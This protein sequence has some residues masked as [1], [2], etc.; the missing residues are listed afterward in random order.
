M[1]SELRSQ[2]EQWVDRGESVGPDALLERVGLQLSTSELSAEVGETP[3]ATRL[4]PIS[5]F[6]QWISKPALVALAAALMTFLAVGAIGVLTFRLGTG[7]DAVDQPPATLTTPTPTTIPPVPETTAPPSTVASDATGAENGDAFAVDWM[8]QVQDVAVSKH[9]PVYVSSSSAIASRDQAGNW[10]LI[11]VEGLPEGNG[12]D[13]G[14]PS[15][16][17]TN[18]A[19]GSDGELWVAG[20]ATSPADDELFG[21]FLE[22]W[23][24]GRFLIWLALHECNAGGCSWR[25]S[26]SDDVPA[27]AQGIDIGDMVVSGDGTLYAAMGHNQLLV[28]DGTTWESHTVP[29]LPSDWDGAVSPWSGSLAVSEDGVVWA[30][31]NDPGDGR[32][33]FAFD[34]DTFTLYRT[35]DGLPGNNVFQ[36]SATADGTIWVATDTLYSDP[37]SASPDAAAGIASFDGSVWT[38][39]TADDGLLSNDAVVVAGGDGSVWAVHYEIPPYGYA[40]FDGSDWTAYPVDPPVGGFRAAVTTDGVLWTTS[41]AGLVTFDGTTR[42]IHPSPFPSPDTAATPE[43]GAPAVTG[44][45]AGER[46]VEITVAGIEG[47][48]GG[49][50]AGVLYQGNGIH[51]PDHRGIGGFAAMLDSDPF[52]TTRFV[53]TPANWDDTGVG[54][55]PYVTEEVLVVEPGTFTLVLWRGS[56]EIGPYSRWVPGGPEGLVSCEIVFESEEG[57]DVSLTVTGGFANPNVRSRCTLAN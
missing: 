23:T 49:Q 20:L 47:M 30:G 35:E 17:I 21:G 44:D 2:L 54:P 12:L 52:S 10:A 22:E 15:R 45:V 38:S 32:G 55:F 5:P 51:D 37:S 46:T 31:T 50:L 4:R 34:G 28:G 8:N 53:T 39:Y 3:S 33:L 1:S 43:T 41:P 42:R 6:R 7:S 40:R 26:T 24:G 14:L 25:I 29:D 48:A 56:S 18:I 57:E 11:D 27:L 9:G 19:T 36:V 16:S 13:D